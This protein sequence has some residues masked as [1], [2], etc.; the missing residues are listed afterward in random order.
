Q[1]AALA[2]PLRAA[3]HKARLRNVDIGRNNA[4]VERRE[5]GWHNNSAEKEPVNAFQTLPKPT[6]ASGRL[7]G[8]VFSQYR[9]QRIFQ[10]S[11][12]RRSAP[13]R[14]PEAEHALNAGRSINKRRLI[15]A[16]PPQ[17]DGRMTRS[18]FLN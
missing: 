4:K 2:L 3:H 6:S 5:R 12:S 9:I 7:S 10:C 1:A 13:G 16:L 11:A 18:Q 14:Y 15:C 8:R 17:Y